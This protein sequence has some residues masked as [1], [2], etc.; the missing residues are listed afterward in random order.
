MTYYLWELLRDLYNE[1]GQLQVAH[2]TG[3]SDTTL[4]DTKLTGTGSD[5]DWKGGAVIILEAGGAA[6][7]GEIMRVSG[8]V[9]STGTLTFPALTA[10]VAA[11]DLYGLVS[12]YFS[13][14]QMITLANL[15][16]RGLGDVLRV[17]TTTLDTVDDQTEYAAA[18]EWKRRP[19]KQIDIQGNTD[20]ANDNKWETV[21]DWN[22]VPATP[23]NTGLIIFKQQLIAGRDIRVWYEDTHA[24]VSDFDDV[25][26]EVFHPTLAVAAVVEKALIWQISRLDGQNDF[27]IERLNDSRTEL[28]RQKRL[29]PV[30]IKN[31]SSRGIV[32]SRK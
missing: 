14:Q 6:P 29:H 16:L 28:D 12:E 9:D 3:G 13:L 32:I 25:I 1:L 11:D 4:V 2:A 30:F 19:P 23:G 20:D 8:Y 15:A 21:T 24:K 18:V 26:D 27:M 10:G 5:D 22:Y 17:D 31:R 7:E